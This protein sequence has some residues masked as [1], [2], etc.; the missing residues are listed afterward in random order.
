MN[1]ISFDVQPGE[2]LGIVGRNGAGKSTLLK[3]LSQITAPT[4]GRIELNG[5][6][7]SLLEVGTGFHPELSGRENI[8]LNGALLGMTRG[9]ITRH[10]DEIVAFA[11]IGQFLD[12]PVKRY[13]SG[14]FV[15]LAFAVAAHLTS[16][17]LIIDEVL[18]VGDG[19]F[20]AKCL[21]KM[22]DVGAS[23]R[24]VLFVSHDL[25]A[26]KALC[27]RALLLQNGRMVANAGVDEVVEMF[28]RSML[29]GDQKPDCSGNAADGLPR[30]IGL[31]LLDEAGN[32]TPFVPFRSSPTL[33][34]QFNVSNGCRD[35]SFAVRLHGSDGRLK[36][37]I[38]STAS[39]C[40]S[41]EKPGVYDV[42][43]AL[44]NFGC[45]PGHYSW[46]VEFWRPGER[47]PLSSCAG[48]APFEVTAAVLAGATRPYLR[49][50]GD[51]HLDCQI[52]LEHMSSQLSKTVS[53][54]L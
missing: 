19:G 6:V 9:E 11:E 32:E 28:M 17:I 41:I 5:R 1:D 48:L 22:R 54:A 46:T 3:I 50:A 10:F 47:D 14:M 25:A 20:Q 35:L 40:P 53:D 15:R 31:A 34:F 7:A 24:T 21:G 8:Y 16:E 44:P 27:N 42:R 39:E 30:L 51:F 36:S 52:S 33:S 12:V 37:T 29:G 2:V 13:S 49:W 38:T 45:L 26:V 23:G 18:A 43:I 4:T